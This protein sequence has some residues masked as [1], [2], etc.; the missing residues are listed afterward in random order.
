MFRPRHTKN[1]CVVHQRKACKNDAAVL[2]VSR[3]FYWPLI[4]EEQLSVNDERMST[5]YLL[6]TSGVLARDQCG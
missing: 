5:T 3:R 1:R 6:T 2:D 4:Q